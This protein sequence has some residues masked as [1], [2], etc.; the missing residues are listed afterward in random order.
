MAVINVNFVQVCVDPFLSGHSMTLAAPQIGR[1]PA[2]DRCLPHVPGLQQTS[3]TS[4]QLSI[5]RADRLTDGQTDTRPLRRRLRHTMRLAS[6]TVR[7]N[8]MQFKQ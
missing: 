8:V 4:L 5:E 3:S 7:T 6:I 2:I 1:R